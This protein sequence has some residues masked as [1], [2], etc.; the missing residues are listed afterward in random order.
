M[1]KSPEK[2]PKHLNPLNGATI[3]MISS[4]F[5][6]EEERRRDLA[7]Y[8]YNV[9]VMKAR[10]DKKQKLAFLTIAER[11]THTRCMI[12]HLVA[13]GHKLLKILHALAYLFST[14][15]LAI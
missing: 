4:Q 8:V 9:V 13:T 7:V 6:E 10:R 3:R 2:T 5:L 14:N 15:L 1:K 12:P 11:E